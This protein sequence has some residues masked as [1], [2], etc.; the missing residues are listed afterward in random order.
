MAEKITHFNRCEVKLSMDF[1]ELDRQRSW[2]AKSTELWQFDL[3]EPRKLVQFA[4]DRDISIF[5]VKTIEALWWSGLLRADVIESEEE[6]DLPL[7]FLG[8]ENGAYTYCDCRPVQHKSN[9]Y[10]GVFTD[11]VPALNN[12]RLYFHP[13][14]LY[15]LHH[16]DRVFGSTTSSTQ[17]LLNPQGL[18]TLARKEIEQFDHWTSSQTCSE[19]FEYW[20]R[21]A[22]VAIALEPSSYGKVFHA[23]RWRYPDD[24]ESISRKLDGYRK[25]IHE[26]L[27]AVPTGEINKLRENLC[28][29]AE[30]IDRNKMVHVLLRLM[31]R[32]ERMKLRSSL[33]A[34]MM[35][36]SMAE[37]IRRGAE[38]AKGEQLPEEDEMGFGQWMQ[39]ARKSVYGSERVLDST[40]EISRDFLTSLGLDFGTKVKCYLEGETEVGALISAV[41]DGAGAEFVNLRGQVVERKGKGLSFVTSLEND[42]KSHVFSVILLDGDSSDNVRALKKAARDE[43]FFGRFFVSSPDFEFANF[44]IDELF[45]V[46]IKFAG[47]QGYEIGDRDGFWAQI[48]KAKSGKEFVAIFKEFCS[49]E[50][51]KGESWGEALM[52]H[53]VQHPDFPEGHE[54]QGATRP[55]IEAARLILTARNAGYMRSI[56]QYQVDSETGELQLR[57]TV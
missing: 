46:A 28:Q 49:G 35:F 31:S 13:F 9:G 15:V 55:I 7:V 5:D 47:E 8:E 36:L 39:G 51:D 12:L 23:L 16:V 25:R 38:E 3:L 26:F 43:R 33:G 19:R 45:D 53:A 48:R 42:K 11:E 41:G 30:F 24:E 17:Y 2:L 44:A 10:G 34:A 56:D 18:V 1:T 57:P 32:H 21:V 52:S 22:E 37:V 40:H 4:K 20:N 29:N 50:I 14:R 54:R 6:V 27:V